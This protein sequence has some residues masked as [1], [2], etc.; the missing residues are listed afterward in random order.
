MKKIIEQYK[1]GKATLMDLDK[2]GIK[3]KPLFKGNGLFPKIIGH[4]IEGEKIYE[5]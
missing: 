2:A 1:K 5:K 3:W 4:I